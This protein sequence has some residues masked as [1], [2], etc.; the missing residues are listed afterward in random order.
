MRKPRKPWPVSGGN[1]ISGSKLPHSK[2]GFRAWGGLQ[3]LVRDWP[4]SPIHRLTQS[5]AY[6]V[7]AG[8]YLKRPIFRGS[9]DLEYLCDRLLE[10][11]EKY[12]WNLQAW[13]VFPNHYH[14]VALSPQEAVSLTQFSKH[15]H[16]VTAIQAN[17]WYGTPGRKV[18]FQYWETK[19]TH[20]QSYLARLSYVH[21]NA[22]HHQV[23]R[24]PSLYP[25]C[26][27]GWFERRASTSF[28]RRIMEMKI[29]RVN[30]EDDFG[31]DVADV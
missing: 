8:T 13:A 10:L 19:L 29:E 12:Q 14:F 15:L 4:H 30:I 3:S 22:V 6:I 26:S 7:T 17:R 1:I 18:W 5:G 23:A 27:A 16:S 25:W 31:V 20:P 11:A 9:Q 21:R 2:A 28:Y 24:E